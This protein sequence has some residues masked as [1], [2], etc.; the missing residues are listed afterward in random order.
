MKSIY[1]NFYQTMIW[2]GN[3]LL[4]FVGA[5][6]KILSSQTCSPARVRTDMDSITQGRLQTPCAS[7]NVSRDVHQ[8]S[9]VIP[10]LVHTDNAGKVNTL[11]CTWN[12]LSFLWLRRSLP[13]KHVHFIELNS[14]LFLFPLQLSCRA[15]PI[16]FLH[17]CQLA[18]HSLE[19]AT[20]T[21]PCWALQQNSIRWTRTGR[22]GKYSLSITAQIVSSWDFTCWWSASSKVK[23][24][25]EFPFCRCFK[26]IQWIV[27]IRL[28]MML[29]MGFLLSVIVAQFW[30]RVW[31]IWTKIGQQFLHF[32]LFL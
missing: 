28:A 4:N 12:P 27:L 1:S 29:R 24:F 15:V 19:W 25:F 13:V 7:L 3:S 30:L 5:L 9:L 16:H 21:I 8:V 22:V 20:S 2:F 6:I 10:V 31:C 23:M 32:Q 14:A 18:L 26:L 11:S 17:C